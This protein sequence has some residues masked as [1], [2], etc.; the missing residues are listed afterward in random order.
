MNPRALFLD[1]DGVINVDRGYV[2]R[3]EDFTFIEGIFDLCRLATRM[4]YLLIVVTNQA[5][6]GRGFYTEADFRKLTEW[7]CEQFRWVGV[8]IS[9]VY[10][11]PDHPEFGLGEYRRESPNRKPNPGMIL[12]AASD[13]NLDLTRSIILGD[14]ASDIQA[15]RAAGVGRCWLLSNDEK[16]DVRSA[17]RLVRDL[18]EA[19]RVL[20]AE[21]IEN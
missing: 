10:H 19:A 3:Q 7:M 16:G 20:E 21:G 1:R 15:G 4:N 2:V 8:N 5:G 13:F 11:C 18:L 17:D 14:K 9:A 6:I 12:Q